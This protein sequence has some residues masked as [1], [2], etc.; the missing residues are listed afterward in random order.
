MYPRVGKTGSAAMDTLWCFRNWTICIPR[1]IGTSL[2]LDDAVKCY[3]DCKLAFA[4]PTDINRLTVQTSNFKAVN[5]VRLA[6]ETKGSQPIH[7][8]I[9]LAVHMLYVVEV[10]NK[11]RTG[12][13]YSDKRRLTCVVGLDVT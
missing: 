4:D 11:N 5:S 13:N 10:S 8:D 1:Y 2:A 12:D 7:G 3:L 9:L 6:L